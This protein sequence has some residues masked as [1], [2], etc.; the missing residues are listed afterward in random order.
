MTWDEQMTQMTS[1]LSF[2]ICNSND[3]LFK[4]FEK[5]Y[6][7]WEF[8]LIILFILIKKTKILKQNWFNIYNQKSSNSSKDFL[9]TWFWYY[10]YRLLFVN[11]III[12]RIISLIIISLMIILSI[13]IKV[14]WFCNKIFNCDTCNG[15]HFSPFYI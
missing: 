5:Y 10:F 8:L 12:D 15:S 1:H 2:V 13:Q 14:N 11:N 6:I 3:L 4:S 9:I 7:F